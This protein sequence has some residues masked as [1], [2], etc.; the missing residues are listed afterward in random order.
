MEGCVSIAIKGG[1]VSFN[2]I[3]NERSVV[4]FL[5]GGEFDFRFAQEALQFDFKDE[6]GVRGYV[7]VGIP[8][9]AVSELCGNEEESS[10]AFA[11]S[12]ESA[13]PTLDESSGNVRDESF[14][15]TATIRAE[16]VTALL[17]PAG[18]LN[19]GDIA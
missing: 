1:A 6:V 14:F 3:D 2:E 16:E 8:L 18:V 11:H 10:A 9:F 12:E 7:D 13:V 19:D 17:D 15:V 4:P 5:C